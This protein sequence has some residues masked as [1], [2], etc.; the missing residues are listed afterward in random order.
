MSTHTGISAYSRSTP[1]PVLSDFI[2]KTWKSFP[3]PPRKQCRLLAIAR[4][5]KSTQCVLFN[6]RAMEESDPHQRFWRPS[7]YH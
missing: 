6:M 3:I 2:L 1:F 4:I 7:F 5:L